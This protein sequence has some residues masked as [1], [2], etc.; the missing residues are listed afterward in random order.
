METHPKQLSAEAKDAESVAAKSDHTGAA[1][2]SAAKTVESET[3]ME[4]S[5]F[6]DQKKSKEEGK[7]DYADKH[8]KEEEDGNYQIL[9]S[10]KTD[11]QMAAEEQESNSEMQQSVPEEDFQ[12]LDSVDDDGETL[13]E[14]SSEMKMEASLQ[15]LSIVPENQA[16]SGEEVCRHVQDVGFTLKE[17]SEGREIPVV[18]ESDSNSAVKDARGNDP[19]VNNEDNLVVDTGVE[20]HSKDVEI[21]KED[22]EKTD[23]SRDPEDNLPDQEIFEVLDS[24]DDQTVQEEDS[25]TLNA[26]S[27]LVSEKCIRPEAEEQYQVIDSL[28]NQPTTTETEVETDIKGRERGKGNKRGKPAARKDDGSSKRSDSTTAP[29]KSEEREKQDKTVKKYETRRKTDTAAGVSEEAVYEIVDSV[30]EESVQVAATAETSG[31]RRSARGKKEEELTANLVEASKTVVSD[32]KAVYKILDSVEDKTVKEEEATV[33]TRQTRGKRTSKKDALIEKTKREDM[34]TRRQ[35]PAR[36]S[37]EQN[38]KETPKIGG[39]PPKDSTPTKKN[40]AIATEDSASYK[41]LDS[42]EDEVVKGDRPATGRKRGRPRKKAKK[43]SPALKKDDRDVA[44][45]E[46]ATYQ[47]LDSVED[48]TVDH[49][50]PA[51]QSEERQDDKQTLNGKSLTGT[52]NTEE[53]DEDPVYQILDSLEDDQEEATTP[54]MS[55][56][57]NAQSNEE[58]PAETEGS[59]T[60]DNKSSSTTDVKKEKSPSP[61]ATPAEEVE[62]KPPE[63]ITTGTLKNL[64]EVSEEE[65]DYPDD[66]AEEEELRRRQAT[67]KDVLEQTA[68]VRKERTTSRRG[69]RSWSSNSRGHY[70]GGKR[71]EEEEVDTKELV[72]LDEVGADEG[73]EERAAESHEEITEGEL[74]TL[75]T[76]DEF[77]EEDGN[78]ELETRPLS[79]ED[80]SAEVRSPTCSSCFQTWGKYQWVLK[81]SVC[82]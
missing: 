50:P 34:P 1:E 43:E 33:T 32:K 56:R 53:E 58:A 27:D 57:Q 24:I 45:E 77:I 35:T 40:D 66:A 12:V 28:E 19:N 29:S 9:D 70:T 22:P 8:T 81:S 47:I 54:D 73:E 42:V 67:P 51:G 80:E 75:V 7:T 76:L 37:R 5:S 18:H 14:E 68:K 38:K 3:K 17:L 65:E 61:A 10:L 71:P 39:E 44:E 59:G 49:Q 20:D 64:D 78:V 16:A 82:L 63:K 30:E 36:E 26:P 4:T 79:H 23:V 2:G 21:Q 69:G 31:R 74:Q 11:E 15:E 6:K 48:E 25:E 72:T 60:R 13:P 62:M 46:E 55:D 52:T 41:I